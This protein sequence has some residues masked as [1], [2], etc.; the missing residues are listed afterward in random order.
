MIDKAVALSRQIHME[1]TQ[2]DV[3]HFLYQ[4]L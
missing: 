2:F 4:H 3:P 1:H